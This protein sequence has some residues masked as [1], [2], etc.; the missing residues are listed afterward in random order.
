MTPMIAAAFVSFA[1]LALA[2]IVVPSRKS[3]E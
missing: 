2:W 3:A 1:A